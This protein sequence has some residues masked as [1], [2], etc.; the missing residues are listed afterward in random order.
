MKMIP[1]L[2][3]VSIVPHFLGIA[4]GHGHNDVGLVLG[5]WIFGTLG[6][7]LGNTDV[8]LAFLADFLDYGSAQPLNP[9]PSTLH[10]KPHEPHTLTALNPTP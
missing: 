8:F 5:A 3:E 10:P 2:A 1:Y 7:G 9:K 4:C 6:L